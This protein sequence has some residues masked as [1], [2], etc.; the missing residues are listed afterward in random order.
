MS[1]NLRRVLIV[2][3]SALLMI[4]M[5][6][7]VAP[8][9]VFAVEIGDPVKVT[10][11]ANAVIDQTTAYQD[12]HYSRNHQGGSQAAYNVKSGNG[13]ERQAYFKFDLPDQSVLSDSNKVY[14]SVK[15]KSNSDV[16]LDF[17]VTGVTYSD[18]SSDLSQQG[19]I[20]TE[21]SK[22]MTWAN[23]PARFNSKVE[24]N[25]F[26][27]K[28]P[29]I[30]VVPLGGFTTTKD[31]NEY[32]IDV[33]D[34]VKSLDIDTSATFNIRASQTTAS[35]IY[36]IDSTGNIIGGIFGDTDKKPALIFEKGTV[37]GPNLPYF[38]PAGN[39]TASADD[40][41][42]PANTVDNNRYTRWSAQN[43]AE[44]NQSL[45]VDLGMVKPIGYLGIAFYSGHTRA[46]IFDILVSNDGEVW[47][48]EVMGLQS[49][50][51]GEEV[52]AIDLHS[53]EINARYVRYVGH[54]NNSPTPAQKDWNSLSELQVYP[55]HTDKIAVIIPV[56]YIEPETPD[57]LP[58]TVPG[59]TN[60]D[61][62]AYTPHS[63][64]QVT[65]NS[66]NVLSFGA[67]PANNE[68]D[69]T[70]AII[71]AIKSASA[72]DEIYFPDGVYN[73]IGKLDDST[74]FELKTKVNLRG[75]SEAGTILLSYLNEPGNTRVIKVF[76]KNNISIKN[77][78]ITSVFDGEFST[79]H[80]A[81][82]PEI[83]GPGNGI[84]I[85]QS[86]GVG[87]YNITIENVTI[88]H[89]QRMGV[90]I[91]KSHDITVRNSTFQNATDV[92]AGGAGYGI[93]I[94]GTPKIDRLGF[95]DDTYHVLVE[96]NTFLGPY[97]RHGVIVQY[98][99]HNNLIADNEFLD[100]RLDA[101][102]LHGQD[103]YLNEIRNNRIENVPFGG[104]GVGNTGGTPPNNHSASG[105]GNYFHHNTVINT[106][107]G[108]LVYMGSPGTIIEA[109]TIQ[110]T[111]EY[112]D[113]AGIRIMNAPGTIIKDNH[114]TGN[115]A[116]G[117]WGIMLTED[118]GDVK[119][120]SIGAGSPH[121]VTI[122]G[123]T[124][125]GNTNGLR[126][127]AGT[128]IHVVGNTIRNNIQNDLKINVELTDDD[129]GLTDPTDPSNPINPSVST[130]PSVT[131][132]EKNEQETDRIVFKGL[133][134]SSTTN[135]AGVKEIK[136][137]PDEDLFKK[138]ILSLSKQQLKRMIMKVEEAGDKY[139]IVLSGRIINAA[140]QANSNWVIS[141]QTPIATYELPMDILQQAVKRN[142]GDS[143]TLTME[144]VTEK[145]KNEISLAANLINAK[146]VADSVDF[147]IMVVKG[148]SQEKYNDF[149]NHYVER[150]IDVSALINP[151][152]ATVVSY[153]PIKKSLSF[154]P[155]VFITKD[156]VTKAN[157]K[158]TGNSIYTVI[159]ANKSYEDISTN[160][161]KQE[162]EMLALKSGLLVTKA[163]EFMTGKPLGPNTWNA[164]FVIKKS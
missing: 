17:T 111:T 62:T 30:E 127:D 45:T 103:E 107:D 26:E 145:V 48:E 123:N 99:A 126:I 56:D 64:N 105:S 89:F 116:P 129:L 69:D 144:L 128:D 88:E 51:T 19:V 131:T 96:N 109:N 92:G 59:L 10:A 38:I 23:A 114:I 83:G 39:V 28:S 68:H 4:Q 121:N 157:F 41:N 36:N 86:G 34:F 136:V 5:V 46:S 154:V 71:A 93:A 102:D 44:I 14:F 142:A 135:S 22:F 149:G 77:F 163:C 43:T 143:V 148:D 57:A 70:A 159:E 130:G 8:T 97:L 133:R 35:T 122:T 119:N 100:V 155:S 66:I 61:G 151:N 7:V 98:F 134:V 125:T 40:G 158:R 27:V 94:Q 67:D 132:A 80:T 81:A 60:P 2:T 11:S 18:W 137:V 101:I 42:I 138:A 117:F 106:R 1:G 65:G 32:R 156:S 47:T 50:G 104:I 150:S 79:D 87:S 78:T 20:Q 146:V 141:I 25:K 58:F 152:Q 9:H 33:T 153:D 140:V 160:W 29:D 3:L 120:G 24:V 54:G 21:D 73:L 110:G 13:S 162:I 55:P 49:S 95:D 63:P 147:N 15:G 85:D 112:D 84:Y 118:P 161:A 31:D 6:E 108:I 74:N 52:E 91:N 113:A 37:I 53:L 124:I 12:V 76:N 90:R 72:G 16:R 82:N 139:V 115:T 75:E 164:F